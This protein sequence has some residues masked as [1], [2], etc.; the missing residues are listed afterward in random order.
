M[1]AQ[2]F[3][4]WCLL[5]FGPTLAGLVLWWT[6][7]DSADESAVTVLMVSW[8][9]FDVLSCL[10]AGVWLM[11]RLDAATIWKVLLGCLVG[12]MLAAVNAF[13]TVCAGCVFLVH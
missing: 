12:L 5:A 6:V 7:R 3:L 1:S 8:L 2:R 4:A 9:C 13:I 11:G 10:V